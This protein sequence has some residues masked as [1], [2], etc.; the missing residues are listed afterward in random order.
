MGILTFDGRK[1]SVQG[2][3]NSL[4]GVRAQKAGFRFCDEALRWV[5]RDA[6]KAVKLRQFAD[7]SAEAK[8]KKHFITDFK[9]PEQILYPDHLQPMHFQI[10]SA[11]HALTR[12]PAY[13]ADEAGLGKTITSILCMN[14]VLGRVLVICPPF[15]KYNWADELKKWLVRGAAICVVDTGDP[16]RESLTNANIIII[17]DSLIG[18]GTIQHYLKD[19]KFEWLFVDEAHRY[20]NPD[21]ERTMALVGSDKDAKE[22][23][24]YTSIAER[25]VFLS[26]TPIPN[27][28]PIELFP[29][30]SRTASES[31]QFR[32]LDEYGK[33]F[34]A[35]R[36][37]T[38]YEGKRVIANWDFQGASNLKRLRRELKS[39]LMIRHLKR[40]VLDELPPKNRKLVFLDCPKKLHKFEAKLLSKHTIKELMGMDAKLGD[41]ASYQ[42]EVGIAKL[43]QAIE[44]IRDLLENSNDKLVVFAHH[45][46]V[47]E[48]LHAALK[49]F[50]CLT[51]RGGMNAVERQYKVKL[52]QTDK[53]FKVIVGNMASMGLG[54]TLTKAPG[55][56]VVEYSWVPGENE[57]AEDR[58]HRMTQDKNVYI[59]YLVLRNTLDERKLRSV[60]NKEH[61]I[62]EVMG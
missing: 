34:C 19:Q 24:T 39:K 50:G 51:I 58:V 36:M 54:L 25:I 13:V 16:V 55:V 31:I 17:P 5:T 44:Y 3:Y 8:F 6:A 21:A 56:V 38:R 1:F 47:V 23:F 20:K 46:D 52:F 33:E 57:Q 59:R 27:G 49:D 40:D 53:D 30:L 62:S 43:P 28:K 10:E 32:N 11:W 41:I 60:L 37:V 9:L 7:S 4:A 45:V 2:K 35:G 14:T 48:G 61:N 42:K 22:Y 18:S 15:L 12:S 26:G 29:L